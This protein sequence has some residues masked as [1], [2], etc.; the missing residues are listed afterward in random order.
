M[1]PNPPGGQGS[2]PTSTDSPPD[3]GT[4]EGSSPTQRMQRSCVLRV[5]AWVPSRLIGM[6]PCALVLS[7]LIFGLIFIL[8]PCS[9]CPSYCLVVL[10]YLYKYS[11]LICIFCYLHNCDKWASAYQRIMADLP[12]PSGFYKH[13]HGIKKRAAVRRCNLHCIMECNALC[14]ACTIFLGIQDDVILLPA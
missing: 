1:C 6:S 5:C 2:V 4:P 3:A 10:V 11:I 8:L 13:Y 7:R 12:S 14:N 9:A